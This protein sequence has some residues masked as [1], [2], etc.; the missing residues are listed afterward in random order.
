MPEYNIDE[1]C[2]RLEDYLLDEE[3]FL[4]VLKECVTFNIGE[5]MENFRSLWPREAVTCDEYEA[6]D[7]FRYLMELV[8]EAIKKDLKRE[9]KLFDLEWFMREYK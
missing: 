7:V 4:N 8:I 9:V 1:L 3:G 2:D 5:I 6:K